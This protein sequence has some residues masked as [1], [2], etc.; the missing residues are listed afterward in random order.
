MMATCAVTIMRSEAVISPAFLRAVRLL[1]ASLILAATSQS[2]LA[3]QETEKAPTTEPVATPATFE[4]ARL[5]RVKA[6]GNPFLEGSI[7]TYYTPGYKVRARKLQSFF[8]DELQFAQRQM[9]FHLNV[10]LAVLDSAQYAVTERQLPYPTPSCTGDPPVAMM[11]VNWVG[12]PDVFPKEKDAAAEVR[13]AVSAHGLLWHEAAS[14][15]YDLWGGHELGHA[16]LDAYGI[17]PGT[18]WLNELIASYVLYAYLA[19]EHSEQLWLIDVLEVGGRP[20]RPQ[21]YVSLDDLESN[22]LPIAVDDPRNY[23]W[24]Q[25]QFFEQIKKVYA[26]HGVKFLEALRQA[27]PDGTYKF[28]TLSTSETLRRLDRI[29]PGFGSWA[30]DL[31]S[32]PRTTRAQ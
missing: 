2:G 32:M 25:A 12:G 13:L 31:R 26:R 14:S 11:P 18:R 29:D 4:P 8:S 21:R 19:S 30:R 16:I 3:Q 17:N 6:L 22:F 27:F 1:S 7:P 9:K 23:L 28:A 10:S 20:G 5:E 15:A 24:Y